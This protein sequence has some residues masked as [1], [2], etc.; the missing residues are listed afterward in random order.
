M[1]APPPVSET[2]LIGAN[3]TC[4]PSPNLIGRTHLDTQELPLGSYTVHI[5]LL[6][7]SWLMAKM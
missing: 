1:I 5:S 3:Q 7:D 6:T 2:D 4:M